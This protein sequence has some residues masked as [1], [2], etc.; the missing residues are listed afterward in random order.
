M[1]LPAMNPLEI[2]IR[3]EI[4]QSGPIPFVRFMELALYCPELGFYNRSPHRIGARGDF[5]TSVSVG[6]L[7]GQLLAVQFSRWLRVKEG[8][9]WI[10]EAGAHDGRL[11]HDLLT[12]FQQHDKPLLDRLEYVI[13]EPSKRRREWQQATLTPFQRNLRWLDDVTDPGFAAVHGIV[14]ANELLD[15]F[16][17]HRLGW[18]GARQNWFEW[19]VAVHEDQLT[20][21]RLPM[22]G[23]VTAFAPKVPSDL[24]KH[25]PNGFTTEV[26]P[27]ATAWWARVARALAGGWLLTVDYGLRSEEY[28]DPGRAQGTLRAYH[29]HRVSGE[30]LAR[31]GEQD[32]TAHLNFTALE[33]AGLQE[34]LRTVTWTTQERFLTGIV[35]GMVQDQWPGRGWSPADFRQFQ[36][37]THPD[38]LGARHQVLVQARPEA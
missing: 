18:D 13:L 26:C 20:W 1:L 31:P 17:V 38:H 37:L 28:F 11:A 33:Q 2:L 15:A 25:L 34:G 29:R 36:S 24:G 10:V 22:D 27:A 9:C 32:L 23:A 14:F 5:Y 4:D 7:F 8:P 35:A 3:D 30:L 21:I 16:P 19:G 6:P 12:W